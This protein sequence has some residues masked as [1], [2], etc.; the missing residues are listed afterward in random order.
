MT[1]LYI[2]LAFAVVAALLFAGVFLFTFIKQAVALAKGK[3]TLNE[4]A[5]PKAPNVP[6]PEKKRKKGS[7][8]HWL[9][10]PSPLNNWG[11]WN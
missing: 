10:L 4:L 3:T 9:S 2:I 8:F 7:S 5:A 1:F 11:L 6:K